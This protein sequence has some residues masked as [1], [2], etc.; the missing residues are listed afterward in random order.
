MLLSIKGLSRISRISGYH[1]R[2]KVFVP[3]FSCVGLY[4]T[5]DGSSSTTDD[6]K[7]ATEY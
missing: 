6:N 3:S 1:F 4:N 5:V 7:T 2:E